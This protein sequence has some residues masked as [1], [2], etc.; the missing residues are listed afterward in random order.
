MTAMAASASLS[1]RVEAK[2]ARQLEKLA[3]VTDRPKSWLLE[4]ALDAYLEAQA[5]QVAHMERGL[6][7]LRRGHALAHDD[8]AAWLRTWGRADEGEPPR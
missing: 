2:K 3:A 1:F 7:E 5:W 6:K 4:Q 8:V